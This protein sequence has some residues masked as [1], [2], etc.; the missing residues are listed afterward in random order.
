MTEKR[1]AAAAAAAATTGDDV[2][3]AAKQRKVNTIKYY[4]NSQDILGEEIIVP[5]SDDEDEEE[6]D[7]FNENRQALVPMETAE[8][9]G[10]MILPFNPPTN[11]DET[12][13]RYFNAADAAAVRLIPGNPNCLVLIYKKLKTQDPWSEI[14]RKAESENMRLKFE[15][16]P[17]GLFFEITDINLVDTGKFERKSYVATLN[18]TFGVFLPTRFTF[19]ITQIGKEAFLQERPHLTYLGV[20]DTN[21]AN[22]VLIFK[23][24]DLFRPKTWANIK[25]LFMQYKIIST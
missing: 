1:T 23:L 22:V 12:R 9:M 15:N 18:N 17:K 24:T 21:K 19:E 3:V 13:I 2:D 7:V 20:N 14:E 6:E 25:S 16:F 8:K 10:E 11:K 5:E 4:V